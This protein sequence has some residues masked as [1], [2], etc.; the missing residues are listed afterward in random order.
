M[1]RLAILDLGTMGAGMA[2]NWPAKGFELSG[3]LAQDFEPKDIAAVA[4]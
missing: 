2:A 3:I 4:G 1:Q